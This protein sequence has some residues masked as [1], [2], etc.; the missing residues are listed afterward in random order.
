[1]RSGTA[2]AGCSAFGRFGIRRRM[3]VVTGSTPAIG[4]RVPERSAVASMVLAAFNALIWSASSWA[5]ACGSAP[6]STGSFDNTA[7]RRLRR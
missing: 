5:G 1:M 4:P 2:A 7:L 6:S 3:R